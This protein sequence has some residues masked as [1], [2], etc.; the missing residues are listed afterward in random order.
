MGIM[1][2][3]YVETRR[4]YVDMINTVHI[5]KR[6]TRSGI[7]IDAYINPGEFFSFK[8]GASER[9]E[10]EFYGVTE[11]H[12]YISMMKE[13]FYGTLDPTEDTREDGSMYDLFQGPSWTKQRFQ[14]GK[15]MGIGGEQLPKEYVV[16]FWEEKKQPAY[17]GSGNI[18]ARAVGLGGV[19]NVE[20]EEVER[21]RMK[22]GILHRFKIIIHDINDI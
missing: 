18:S 22:R 2:K 11:N 3:P 4:F 19:K 14:F 7:V 9:C 15:D 8:L 6:E 20:V 13:G 17:R 21:E 10:Y 1:N 12:K 5:E 16:N